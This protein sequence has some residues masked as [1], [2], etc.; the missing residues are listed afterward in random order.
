MAPPITTGTAAPISPPNPLDDTTISA[1]AIAEAKAFDNPDGVDNN[2]EQE[3]A[4]QLLNAFGASLSKKRQEAID[5]RYLSGVED[6][7]LDDEDAI[8]GIDDAN[9]LD[10]QLRNK[11]LTPVTREKNQVDPRSTMFLNITRPYCDAA[12]A[13]IADMMLPISGDRAFAVEPTPI[14]ELEDM[15]SK[16]PALNIGG[17]A[18]A[19]APLTA[20]AT[21]GGQAAPIEAAPDGNEQP[22][23]GAPPLANDMAAGGGEP[24]MMSPEPAPLSEPATD[25]GT[26]SVQA[27]VPPAGGQS[28]ASLLDANTQDTLKAIAAKAALDIAAK[29]AEKAELRID[30]WFKETKWGQHIRAVI[31]DAA[32]VGNGIIKGPVP[33]HRRAAKWTVNNGTGVLV[34]EDKICPASRRIDYWDF[35]PDPDCGECIHDGAFTWERD[36]VTRKKLKALK[37]LPGYLDDQIDKVLAEGPTHKIPTNYDKDDRRRPYYSGNTT[38][39]R[40]EIW[41]YYGEA[42]KDDMMA[43]GCECK[44]GDAFDVMVTM[45]N[46]T[47][48]RASINV[49]D[50]GEFPYDIM[51]WQ[52]RI[53]L[54]WGIG[55]ARQ[56]DTPQR[57][58]KA[59]SRNMADNAAMASGPQ[60]VVWEKGIEPVNGSHVLTPR[61][62]W[63]V[64]EDADIQEVDH[65]F[66]TYNIEMH[67]QELMVIITFAL[68]MAEQVTNLPM[69]LQGQIGMAPDT[70]GG[71][72]MLQNNASGVLRRLAMQFDESIII[73]HVTRYYDW[74]MQYGE[75][76]D[77]K[78]DMQIVAKGASVLFERDQQNQEMLQLGQMSQNPIYGIDP[79]KW[80]A[81]FMRSKHYNPERFQYDANDDPKNGPP[82]QDPRLQIE[83]LRTDAEERRM[84]FQANQNDQSRQLQYLLKT[85]DKQLEGMNIQSSKDVELLKLR[86]AVQ[87]SLAASQRAGVPQGISHAA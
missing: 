9:R 74:I 67:V 71:M 76:D 56:I 16:L 24:P 7:W 23:G 82:Q 48:I 58:L 66:R 26:A 68:K 62:V 70:V 57:L 39:K 59:A 27:A 30:D 40:F 14:P 53:G 29:K 32:R 49:L 73:P 11:S 86:K 54:P 5:G 87:D 69:L 75:D 60:V 81:E 4:K 44:D 43:A 41:Y 51:V 3:A 77:E 79:R 6:D 8:E 21:P 84:A 31:E 37:G 50:T 55:I 28:T 36:R 13:R 45:V 18:G 34:I 42:G 65:A 15:A 78:G 22:S 33:M 12:A 35:F 83:Q 2:Q 25:A 38:D 10:W 46:D 85:M 63:I 72:T 1:A 17:D 19:S 47:V 64:K 52:K 20:A 80:A 61:K